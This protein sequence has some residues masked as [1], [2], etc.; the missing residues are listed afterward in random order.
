MEVQHHTALLL[1]QVGVGMGVGVLRVGRRVQQAGRKV[2][3]MVKRSGGRVWRM[4]PRAIFRTGP[5]SSRRLLAVGWVA[6]RWRRGRSCWVAVVFILM[7][8]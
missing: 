5:R 7:A 6:L 4:I 1:G 8:Q 2:G 3:R